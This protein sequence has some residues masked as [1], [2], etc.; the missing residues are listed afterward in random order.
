MDKKLVTQEII[1][2]VI[3]RCPRTTTTAAI[4][5]MIAALEEGHEDF[6]EFLMAWS[7]QWSEKAVYVISVKGRP[8]RLSF[9]EMEKL[10]KE[11]GYKAGKAGAFI[12][13][14]MTK[15]EAESLDQQNKVLRDN[16]AHVGGFGD[17]KYVKEHFVR[18][19][20]TFFA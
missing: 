4:K 9:E 19:Q 18:Y 10:R 15:E 16:G 6:N 14:I 11:Q 20:R 7:K 8:C 13:K 17:E 3:Y 5:L 2:R 1:S 12:M